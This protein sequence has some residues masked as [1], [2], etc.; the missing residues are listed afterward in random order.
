MSQPIIHSG[1]NQVGQNIRSFSSKIV[2]TQRNGNGGLL[3]IPYFV[4]GYKRTCF[5]A[6]SL[7][8]AMQ[9]RA[10]DGLYSGIYV[11]SFSVF[12]TKVT[13]IIQQIP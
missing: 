2:S 3:E 13:V 7:E 11:T 12:H 6:L 9:C 1:Q 4:G 10:L 8:C 5:P